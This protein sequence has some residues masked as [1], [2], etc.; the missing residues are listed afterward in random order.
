MTNIPSELYGEQLP[1]PEKAGL[2]HKQIVESLNTLEKLD[3]KSCLNPQFRI[4]FDEI[5]CLFGKYQSL[6][7]NHSS[8][9]N[10]CRIKCTSCCYH[11]VEDINSF[12]AEIIADYIRKNMAEQIP[13]IVKICEEDQKELEHLYKHV[14]EKLLDSQDECGDIDEV[15]LLLSVFYQMRRPCPLLGKDGI[16]QVYQV[17]PL[18]CRIYMSFSDPSLCDPAYINDE[19]IPTYLLNLEDDANVILDRLH[20]KYLKFEGDTGLRSLLMKY[21]E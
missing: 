16:C 8:V 20:F 14:Q 13:A 7:L 2:I 6:V 1:V 3:L 15:D 21:L 12:E 5:L 18:T 19:F 11:W 9:E 10:T 17:R 4:L